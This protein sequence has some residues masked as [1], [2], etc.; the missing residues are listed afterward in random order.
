M[1]TLTSS[2]R[3]NQKPLSSS[4]SADRSVEYNECYKNEIFG[5]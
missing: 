1:L 2:R 3:S 4:S 5:T